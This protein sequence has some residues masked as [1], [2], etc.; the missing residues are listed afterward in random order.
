MHS[1]ILWFILF[2]TFPML[3]LPG[4]GH[5]SCGFLASFSIF[6]SSMFL[7]FHSTGNSNDK[8]LLPI[9]FWV[10]SY[11]FLG[12]APVAQIMNDG[13]PWFDHYSSES[14]ASG[15][16]VVILGM[17]FYTVGYYSG[18]A[19]NNYNVSSGF[20]FSG[21]RLYIFLIGMLF[22]SFVGVLLGGGFST[23][24][25]SRGD[26]FIA[27]IGSGGIATYML[28]QALMKIPAFV[29]AIFFLYSYIKGYISK[30]NFNL[31]LLILSILVVVIIN[32]PLSTARFWFGVVTLT[33]V[34]MII[35]LSRESMA[36]YFP[37][38]W[39]FILMLVFPLMDLFRRTLDVDIASSF[40]E[41]SFTND[42]AN[43]ADFDSF[44]QIINTMYYV[45]SYGL[46]L[47][48]QLISS[49]FFWLPRSLWSGKSIATGELVAESIG[50]DYLNLS[51]PLWSEFYIDF[52]WFGLVLGMFLYGRVSKK[53]EN[54]SLSDL[55][56]IFSLFFVC[57]QI[58]FLRGSLMVTMGFLVVF[59][60]LFIAGIKYIFP[61][62]YH[63]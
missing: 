45:E 35:Y 53:I 43:S 4:F 27:R 22:L 38:L 7:A 58:Y 14:I 54:T 52:G 46:E 42:L 17:L 50:Y 39:V 57:Y 21:T 15:W 29:G 33:I 59:S 44:Q 20:C 26:A 49:L 8:G 12:V 37:S 36:R 1:W 18:R 48:S 63:G 31:F 5:L 34:M 30:S 25:V 9:G 13:F 11:V 51:N 19:S 16:V 60:L 55:T 61:R 56:I 6:I 23:L 41:F 40:K 2:F 32:N 28:L 47:G 62:N 3:I 10:Y 24:F